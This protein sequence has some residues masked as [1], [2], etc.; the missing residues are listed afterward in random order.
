M[1]EAHPRDD[2]TK[3]VILQPTRAISRRIRD[4]DGVPFRI[5]V[6]VL[7]GRDNEDC[8]DS[9]IAADGDGIQDVDAFDSSSLPTE[10]ALVAEEC[11]E[12]HL[13]IPTVLGGQQV[14]P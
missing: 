9:V 12:H 3:G 1:R 14:F 2:G 8:G 13:D 5:A 7:N 10:P 4:R 11:R 6:G